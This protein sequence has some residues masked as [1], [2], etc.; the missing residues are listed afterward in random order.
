MTLLATTGARGGLPASFGWMTVVVA[1]VA[2]SQAREV[3]GTTA[4]PVNRHKYL[5]GKDIPNCWRYVYDPMRVALAGSRTV[6][7]F[8]PPSAFRLQTLGNVLDE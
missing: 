2:Q 5:L 8:S 3:S 7:N 1:V 4:R 6:T